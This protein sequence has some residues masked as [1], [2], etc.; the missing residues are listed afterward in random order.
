MQAKCFVSPILM[1]VGCL[2]MLN[3]YSQDKGDK[4]E[5]FR[6]N[7]IEP[8][9]FEK[10]AYELDT[11]AHAVILADVGTSEFEM[12]R[13]HF[14]IRFK[15]TCRIKIIDNNGY[16]AAQVEIPL[17]KSGYSEEK[18]LN[19]KGYSYNLEG[20]KVV[21]TKMDGKAVFTD[22][23]SRDY[24]ERKFTLPAVKAG[25]IIE[26]SYTVS[27]PFYFNLQP[28]VYQHEYPCL[29]SE[30][31]VTIP[32]FFDFAFLRQGYQPY[33]ID[34]DKT[35][36]RRVYNMTYTEG[37]EAHASEHASITANVTTTHW[38]MK[39][40]PAL[41]RESY[42]TTLKNHVAKIEF[43]L[44]RVKYPNS[45]EKPVMDTWN[46]LYDRLLADEEFGLALD[47]NNGYLGDVVDDLIKGQTTDTAKAR[48]IFNYVRQNFTCTDHSGLYLSKPL[49]TVFSSHNG[50]ETDINLL[51]VAML[52]RA[53]LGS[54]PVIMS[55][56]DHGYTS[57]TY[58]MI[59]RFN[60]TIASLAIDSSL[61]YLDASLPYLGF[62]KLDARCYNGHARIIAPGV[63]AVFFEPGELL[64]KKN[65]FVMLSGE[66]GVIK[67]HFEQ[68]PTYFESCSLR[69]T[70][71][72]KGQDEFF[73][74]I[75]K[76]FSM[77]TTLSNKNI[78]DLD[79]YEANAKV[80]YDFE[81]KPEEDGMLYINPML[82]E[83]LRENPFKSQ[84][85]FYPVEMP[86]IF[87]EVYT[88]S[89]TIPEGFEVEEIPKPAIVKFNENDGVFQY[90]IQRNENQIQ[91][92]S[93]IK[94]ERATFSPD[95]YNSL[96]QF[97]DMVV[98]K[99]GEQIVLKKK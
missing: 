70:V 60:Y 67:G 62:G 18:I 88:L 52:R 7:R 56:R 71:K 39:N 74:P 48:R 17:M 72:Q 16:D 84:D 94:L 4:P 69:E 35:S 55:T 11:G 23:L 40:I 2:F 83:A 49:K 25:T 90:L 36:D 19:L 58:P 87:D 44:A 6:F 64:E 97:F 43:Q 66:N 10:T 28:W 80:V 1:V 89:M 13:D 31:S 79:D 75:S 68:R 20:G 61:Y 27:S 46:K 33:V 22:K 45:P 34:N 14:E 26:Y 91:L 63:P 21:E 12:E 78:E 51:L 38:A 47:K 37:S 53:K 54:Y 42:T 30:Y 99:Q 93:R 98:K 5:K 95:E 77:E 96:R 59:T 92:R 76:G 50:N 3:V 8:K 15:R 81:M 32:E 24:V 82:S 29:W 73:K 86:G 9:D 85:R 41:K 65:T 57:S